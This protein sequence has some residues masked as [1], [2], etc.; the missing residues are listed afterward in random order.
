MSTTRTT[1]L[2]HACD[3]ALPAGARFCPSCGTRLSE[4]AALDREMAGEHR[5]ITVMFCDVVGSTELASRLDPEDLRDVLR[6]YQSVCAQEIKRHHGMI[7]HYLGDGVIACFGYPRARE[8]SAIN[9]VDAALEITRRLRDLGRVTRAGQQVD[10]AAR[11]SLH[12]GRVLVGEMGSGD[13]RE[14]HAL[15]GVTPNIAARLEQHAPTN[16][17][18]ISAQT[19]ALVEASFHLRSL[20]RKELKGVRDPVEVFQVTGRASAATVLRRTESPLI[21]RDAELG[22]LLDL[23]RRAE[24]GRTVRATVTAEPG[25]GKST[26]AA[27]FLARSGAARVIE[28][29]GSEAGRDTPFDA[30]TSMIERSVGA[31]PDPKDPLAT[32]EGW[33]AP[34]DPDRARHAMTLL[35]LHEREA[36]AI[37]DPRRAVPAAVEALALGRPG[38]LLIAMEDAHWMDASS[39]E[40]VDQLCAGADRGR[41][42]LVLARP[43]FDFPWTG[44]DGMRID[45][46]GLGPEACREVIEANAGGRVEISAARHIG[47]TTSCLPLYVEEFTKALIGSGALVLRR[48]AFR[49]SDTGGGIQTPDSLLGLITARLDALGDARVVAQICA[50]LGSD[51]SRAALSEVGGMSDDTIDAAIATLSMAGVLTVS[52]GGSLAFRHA[53]YQ[54]AAY[55][56]LVRNARETWH[57]RYLEWIEA[58][59]PRLAATRPETLARHLEGCGRLEEAAARY[60]AAG[61]SAEA[62][63]ASREAAAHFAK[64]V[65]LRERIGGG[66]GGGTATLEARV[67]LAGAL[68]SSRGPGSPETR[69]AYD[70]A[71]AIADR[72][73]ES[74]WH[75]PAYWGWWRVSD[76]FATMAA[77]ANRIL[78]ASERM[79]GLEF[80]L[81]AHHCVWA[82]S[83]Q[84]GELRTSETSAREGL[85][86]YESGGFEGQGKLYGGHDCKVCAL[87]ELALT[88]WLQGAGDAAVADAETALAHAE[89]LE[90][91]GSV[92]HALDITVMLHHYRRDPIAVARTAGE[93]L[94]L[95]A[96]HELEEYSAK[97]R[98]FEGWSLVAQGDVAEGLRR[99]DGGFEVMRE[100]GTPEDF[101]VYQCMRAD[102]MRRLGDV[103]AALE[104]L[105]EGSAVI[106]A[107]GVNYWG[108]EIARHRALAETAR[109]R[110][111]IGFIETWLDEAAGIAATQGALALELRAAAD[112]HRIAGDAATRRR[113]AAVLDRLDPAARGRD[114]DDARA[115]LAGAGAPEPAK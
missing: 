91:L 72:T 73:P 60:L 47:E 88:G 33:F 83:F 8:D 66:A 34:D 1:A 53:L 89:K 99:I 46:A 98:I 104:V 71:L 9:G 103:D 4:H 16:G 28:M 41:M 77:R 84:R 59:P 101:P 40:I 82:N 2:C 61:H 23:W 94:T 26:L 102:A 56:S 97:G 39:L 20:G 24:S 7:S 22:T 75:F 107:E 27:A 78:T 96:E 111:D 64:C 18:V 67:L 114:I 65:E 25:A 3:S 52:R 35:R 30:L 38:P 92:M 115:A 63:S 32:I 45:L 49:P 13:T 70:A 93:I 15:T 10:L 86:L 5:Q 11:I 113:L 29:A 36:A 85:S 105:A 31:D 76:S 81:Q 14:H 50:V 55:E 57:R 19:R 95:S 74:E 62:A 43:E 87:G 21:G 6:E 108:A 37:E 51:F 109:P 42:L 69:E 106:V 58:D 110:P 90:H 80:R 68:L 79:E 44:Q 54:T 112:R 17:V 100:I 48:G 12:T